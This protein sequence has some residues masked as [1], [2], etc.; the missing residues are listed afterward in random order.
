MSRHFHFGV[1]DSS[2][3]GMINQEDR[4]ASHSCP[5]YTQITVA[6][7]CGSGAMA[8]NVWR[9]GASDSLDSDRAVQSAR[10]RKCLPPS[11]PGLPHSSPQNKTVII[12]I[13]AGWRAVTSLHFPSSVPAQW[14]RWH[15]MWHLEVQR[16]VTPL[17]NV[18]NYLNN[19]HPLW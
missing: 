14:S 9:A 5:L 13:Y 7:V 17:E 12:G 18:L 3:S 19:R 10:T 1:H 15:E 11:H 8:V 4:G 16:V 2:G 6:T